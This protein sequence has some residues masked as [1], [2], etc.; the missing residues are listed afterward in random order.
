MPYLR[1]RP[2]IPATG[3]VTIRLNTAQR[4]LLM[5]AP[6]TPRELGHRLHRAPVHKGKLE[7]RV[8]RNELAALIASA[9]KAPAADRQTEKSLD[10][11]V[12]YLEEIEE[13][14]EREDEA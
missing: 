11:F 2:K 10:V 3:R 7:L 13:R 6:S 9:V 12:R 8:D 14:F 1:Q 5:Q 4:D